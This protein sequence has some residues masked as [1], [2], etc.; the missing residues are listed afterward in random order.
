[1]IFS[2][3][4]MRYEPKAK[5]VR[6]VVRPKYPMIM[7]GVN[8]P[9]KYMPFNL[10]V[11]HCIQGLN[12]KLKLQVRPA[13]FVWE[14]NFTTVTKNWT[15]A[16]HQGWSPTW[17]LPVMLQFRYSSAAPAGRAVE[18]ARTAAAEARRAG[19]AFG[20]AGGT[21]A[22]IATQAESANL[23]RTRTNQAI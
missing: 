17:I 8:S 18:A 13:S 1:M 20:W 16:I 14:T 10:Q 23:S 2:L 22:L 21:K 11:T 3:V 12:F 9:S 4:R 7:K 19:A 6:K 15:P 5:A